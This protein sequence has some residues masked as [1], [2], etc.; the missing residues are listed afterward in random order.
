MNYWRKDHALYKESDKDNL[1][2]DTA[3]FRVYRMERDLYGWH[4]D[5]VVSLEKL[6]TLAK[7]ACKTFRVTSVPEIL[8][9]NKKVVDIGWCIEGE[10]ITLNTYRHGQNYA[11]LIHEIA[12]W[13]ADDL[14][15]DNVGHGPE[16]GFIYIEL[17]DRY[18]FMPRWLMTQLFDKYG[19]EY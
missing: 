13:I 2:G 1:P 10:S 16:W 8:V 5:T 4:Y 19:I 7:D 12:H 6:Q 9:V 3:A 15:P 18:K 11:I 17:L 14:Y